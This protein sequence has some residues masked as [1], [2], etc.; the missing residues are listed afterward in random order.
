[1]VEALLS[2]EGLACGW[3]EALWGQRV[4]LRLRDLLQL[5]LGVGT[6]LAVE[7]P[8]AATKKESN[9]EGV[10]SLTASLP[11][12]EVWGRVCLAATSELLL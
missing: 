10:A 1:M 4:S 12:T 2:P 3:P 8:P 5:L 7:L 11:P 9:K 6:A